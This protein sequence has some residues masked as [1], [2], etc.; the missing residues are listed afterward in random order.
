[1]RRRA[2]RV[3]IP[4]A[5][6]LS[7]LSLLL[8]GTTLPECSSGYFPLWQVE[9]PN[10]TDLVLIYQGGSQRPQWTRDR[11]APYVSYRDPH[12][13]Q[14]KWLFDAFL[15]IELNDGK[16]NAFEPLPNMNPARKDH[17]R[18]LLDKTFADDDGLPNLEQVCRQTAARIGAPLRRRQVLIALPTPIRDQS[19]WGE[20]DGRALDFRK[21][22]DRLAALDWYMDAAIRKW[23]AFAPTRLDLAGFYWGDESELG[24]DDFVSD[25][26]RSVHAHSKMFVW[27]P[28]WQSNNVRANWRAFGFDV[29]WQQPNHFFHPE[30]ADTRLDD[31]CSFARQHGMGLE[32]E[33][34]GRMISDREHFEPRFDAYLNAFTL[35]HVKRS[36]SIAYYEGGGCL[37]LLATSTDP[38]VRAHYDRLAHFILDRQILVDKQ[39]HRGKPAR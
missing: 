5:L 32:L 6:L 1:M 9:K 29:A 35:K 13:G 38:D 11:F 8:W 31:A 28:Y 4:A 15:F 33:F 27:I 36:S 12:S 39:F 14:E 23:N 17:W 16:G 10:I 37:Y 19:D 30:I 7:T 24:T 34:D 25:V 18:A 3:A 21:T 22:T 26:S 2:L 20:L